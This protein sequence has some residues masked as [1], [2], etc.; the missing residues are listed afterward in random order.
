MV[1]NLPAWKTLKETVERENHRRPNRPLWG[2]FFLARWEQLG[3]TWLWSA[4]ERGKPSLGWRGGRKLSVALWVEVADMHR[5]LVLCCRLSAGSGG[6]QPRSRPRIATGWTATLEKKPELPGAASAR[7]TL[8]WGQAALRGRVPTRNEV[9]RLLL[10]PRRARCRGPD[11]SGEEDCSLKVSHYINAKHQ[12]SLSCPHRRTRAS[13]CKRGLRDG[14]SHVGLFCSWCSRGDCCINRLCRILCLSDWALETNGEAELG[15]IFIPQAGIST[16]RETGCGLVSFPLCVMVTRLCCSQ[17]VP[18]VS[19][20]RLPPSF[21]FEPP[22]GAESKASTSPLN[23]QCS[24]AQRLKPSSQRRE[25]GKA[26]RGRALSHSQDTD[27][28]PWA[29]AGNG[30]AASSVRAEMPSPAGMTRR[31]LSPWGRWYQAVNFLVPEIFTKVQGV[32][33]S[34]RP[35]SYA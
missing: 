23:E 10:R 30:I 1:K 12:P 19:S 21:H 5:E 18:C 31:A 6:W 15:F 17:R 11:L 34:L 8:R 7:G 14:E 27:F 16:K 32:L 3:L 25:N 2:T 26:Q 13:Q 24:S 33:Q 28:W 9:G 20:E 4:L 29:P 22:R 35:F